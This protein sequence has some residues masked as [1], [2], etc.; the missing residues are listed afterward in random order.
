MHKS[1][2]MNP[3]QLQVIWDRLIAVVEEQAHALIRSSFST[4]VREGG[5]LSAGVFDTEGRM[6]A[7]AVTGTA[8]HV[9]SMATAVH[10]FLKEFPKETMSEGD[11]YI[12]NDPWLT[13]GHL[14]DITVVTPTFHRGK[15]IGFFAAT[16]HV[17]DIG[18]R[19]MGPDGRQVFEEGLSIPMMKLASQ[20]RMNEDLLK[21]IRANTREPVQVE[22]DL[23]SCAAAGE[24]GGRQL[25]SMMDEFKML[26]LEEAA[27]NI[28]TQSRRAM[29]EKIRMIPSGIYRNQITIDGYEQEIEVN[30]AMHVSDDG[31]HVDYA[32][33]SA[34]SPYGINVVL[35]YTAAYSSYGIRC[36][37][38]ND[39]PNNAGSLST[40]SVVAPP[41]C[42]FN[43]QRPAPVSARHTVGHVCADAVLGCLEHALGGKIPAEGSMMWNLSILGNTWFGGSK[44]AWANYTFNNGGMG[45]RP[46]QDGLSATAYPAGVSIVPVE[47]TEA[48]API[49]FWRKELRPDSGGPGEFRGGVGQII[50]LGSANNADIDVQAMFDRIRNPARGRRG[51]ANGACGTVAL[52]SRR[53]LT[54]KGRQSVAAGERLLLH[55]PGGGGYGNPFRRDPEAVRLDILAGL[56]SEESAVRD[57]G[58]A[59][60]IDRTIDIQKTGMLRSR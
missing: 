10:H 34:A 29:L 38:G 39:I 48:V 53:E 41:G 11:A 4:T 6:L 54:A 49:I 44:R 50:E 55:L 16:V 28:I 46:G 21:I 42:I 19:G 60:R 30:V 5:D 9:N 18:G 26:S 27:E 33:S 2:L 45:A 13:S 59:L 24:Q 3:I 35:N 23:F 8:G 31:I 14:H 20:G 22:G 17:V 47:A 12:T 58:V 51:G 25:I 7:Q 37:I 57:Y 52:S 56:V 1:S 40:I 43:A 32:G 36:V 15:L